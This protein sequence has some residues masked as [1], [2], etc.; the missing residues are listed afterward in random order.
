MG[1]IQDRSIKT[2][3][4]S[5]LDVGSFS[6]LQG[7]SAVLVD[8]PHNEP[9]CVDLFIY[10]FL[11]LNW[12]VTLTS[13]RRAD[14]LRQH[15]T[16]VTSFNERNALGISGLNLGRVGCYFIESKTHTLNTEVIGFIARMVALT[17]LIKY[18]IILINARP[19]MKSDLVISGHVLLVALYHD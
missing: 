17:S 12:T 6:L 16:H 18:V 9:V 8:Y 15:D 19:I 2:I 3:N 13:N 1:S 14:G 10:L 7:E 5:A 11:L 4:L